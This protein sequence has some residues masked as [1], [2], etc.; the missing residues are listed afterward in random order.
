MVKFVS[1]PYID[2]PQQ[3]VGGS[4]LQFQVILASVYHYHL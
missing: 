3:Q 1:I 4:G 2:Q